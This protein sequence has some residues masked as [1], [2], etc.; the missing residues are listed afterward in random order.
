MID[1]KIKPL[2]SSKFWSTQSKLGDHMPETPSRGIF[3]GP[4]SSGKTLTAQVMLKKHYKDVFKLFLFGLQRPVWT[5]AGIL[6][7]K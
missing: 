6:F 7:T 3:L 5:K 2:K 1:L 4:G